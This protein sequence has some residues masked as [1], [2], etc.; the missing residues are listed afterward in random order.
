M[1]RGRNEEELRAVLSQMEYILELAHQIPQV[2]HASYLET[3]CSDNS[4]K[5]PTIDRKEINRAVFQLVERAQA[6][7][8]VS[9]QTQV[10]AW[11][12]AV[13]EHGDMSDKLTNGLVQTLERRLADSVHAIDRA[14]RDAEIHQEGLQEAYQRL[15]D[16]NLE[17]DALTERLEQAQANAGTQGIVEREIEKVLATGDWKFWKTAE[18]KVYIYQAQDTIVRHYNAA[19]GVD[20]TVNFGRFALC[21]RLAEGRVSSHSFFRNVQYQGYI[22]PH[23]GSGICWGNKSAYV[24]EALS[25]NRFADVA[26]TFAELVHTYCPDNPYRTFNCFYRA[27]KNLTNTEDVIVDSSYPDRVKDDLLGDGWRERYA[28]EEAEAEA[29]AEAV[30]EAVEENLEIRMGDSISEI[31]F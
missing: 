29:E 15:R 3:F 1:R 17:H 22:H 8:A 5:L 20:Q 14:Y 21:W 18:N 6:C 30:E 23:V 10:Q 12:E 25:E 28:V 19:A 31:L 13:S 27:R 16:Y 11:Q 7:Q 26:R 24:A 4:T 2:H 9:A